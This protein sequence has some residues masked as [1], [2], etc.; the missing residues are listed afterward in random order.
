MALPTVVHEAIVPHNFE[1]HP[2]VFW[3]VS[4]IGS[5]RAPD[6][7]TADGR[8]VQKN[9]PSEVFSNYRRVFRRVAHGFNSMCIGIEDEGT[10]IIGM[11]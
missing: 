10:E 9:L 2:S 11:V 3:E 8:E 6:R 7:R 1:R 5:G 4:Q